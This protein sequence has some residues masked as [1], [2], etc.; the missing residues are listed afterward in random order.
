V[1]DNRRALA[2]LERLLA[3]H[4]DVRLSE[5]IRAESSRRPGRP[6][7]WDEDKLVDVFLE[8]AI[9]IA[10]GMRPRQACKAIAEYR[11]VALKVV[12]KRYAEGRAKLR[13]DL[14][15]GIDILVMLALSGVRYPERTPGLQPLM[16]F[17]RTYKGAANT[18]RI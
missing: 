11:S 13:S 17:L 16:K 8:V 3:E 5:A 14:P 4:G 1:A 2:L 12:E 15:G 18:T 6:R 10:S 9:A 7:A